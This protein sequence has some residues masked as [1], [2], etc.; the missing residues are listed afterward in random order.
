MKPTI[1]EHWTPLMNNK[2]S[3]LAGNVQVFQTKVKCEEYIRHTYTVRMR[4]LAGI[5]PGK[6]SI[7]VL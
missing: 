5:K 7:T 4:Q 2:V 1:T 3:T 6:I